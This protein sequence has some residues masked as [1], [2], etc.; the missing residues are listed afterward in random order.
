M[1]KWIRYKAHNWGVQTLQ[2]IIETDIKILD[3]IKQKQIKLKGI[4][5][6]KKELLVT[7]KDNVLSKL[8]L[9]KKWLSTFGYD[10]FVSKLYMLV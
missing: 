7:K 10:R 5:A 2:K 6:Q 8:P 1:K 4:A 9:G 3:D